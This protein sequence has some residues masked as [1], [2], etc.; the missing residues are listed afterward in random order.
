MYVRGQ[1]IYLREPFFRKLLE[2]ALHPSKG[3]HGERKTGNEDPREKSPESRTT[4]TRLG[5]PPRPALTSKAPKA[6]REIS[7]RK[8]N[9]QKMCQF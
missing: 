1:D 5:G 2:D 8:C 9:V 4:R 7:P 6:P 3:V